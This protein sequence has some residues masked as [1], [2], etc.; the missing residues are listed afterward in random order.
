MDD[1][2]TVTIGVSLAK[3]RVRRDVA[4]DQLQSQP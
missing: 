4:P 2:F 3:K 1:V